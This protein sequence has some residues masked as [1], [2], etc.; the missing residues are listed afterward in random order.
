MYQ[1][2]MTMSQKQNKKNLKFRTLILFFFSPIKTDNIYI[3]SC[4][5]CMKI[6]VECVKP[7]TKHADDVA[8]NV[9]QFLHMQHMAGEMNPWVRHLRITLTGFNN[10]T[11]AMLGGCYW[12]NQTVAM[13]N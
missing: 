10:S 4:N 3:N 8:S 7:E 5:E 12:Q 11:V 2:H 1:N 9:I 6:K 13:D